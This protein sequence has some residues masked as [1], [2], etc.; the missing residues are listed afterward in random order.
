MKEKICFYYKFKTGTKIINATN[1]GY[2]HL[3]TEKEINKSKDFNILFKSQKFKNPQYIQK[4]L[5]KKLVKLDELNYKIHFNNLKKSENILEY[6]INPNIL[7]QNRILEPFIAGEK[8]ILKFGFMYNNNLKKQIQKIDLDIT[9]KNNIQNNA[10]IKSDGNI[11]KNNNNQIIVTYNGK[12]NEAKII[13]PMNI[14]V[15]SLVS[16]I[17]IIV[18][19]DKDILS[20]VDLEIKDNS[21]QKILKIKKDAMISYEFT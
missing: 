14:N 3:S 18:H 11:M 17:T 13:Y 5:D 2:I 9:Y 7:A 1:E 8:N 15:F 19:L 10:L 20:E 16:K 21:N 12:I 4:K 6:V